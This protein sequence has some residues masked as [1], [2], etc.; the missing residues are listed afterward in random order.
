MVRTS[1]SLDRLHR[2]SINDEGYGH[3]TP[4]N[5]QRR[6]RI[7]HLSLMQPSHCPTPKYVGTGRFRYEAVVAWEQLPVGYQFVEVAGVATDSH[8]RVFV[9]N[10]GL[11]PLIVFDR[12]GKFLT[13]WGEGLFQ[14]PHG[15]CI[16]PD[17]AVYCTDDLDHTVRKFTS[18]GKLLL[19]LGTPGRAAD[20]GVAGIDYRTIQRAG[21]PFHRP[22]NLALAADG[23]MY[24]TDGYGNARVHKFAP[25]GGLLFSWGEPGRGFGQFQVPHGIAVDQEGLV[26][27]AD[28]ENSRIQLFRPNGD[29][30]SA[31]TDVARPTQVVIDRDGHVFVAE[32]GWRAGLFPWQSP[33]EPNPLGAR[34][35]VFTRAGDLLARWGDADDPT[36]PG[37]FFAPHD[38]WIDLHGDIYVGEVTMSAGGNRGAVPADCHSLQKFVLRH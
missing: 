12:D 21:P 17:D 16:G 13:S 20:T 37:N 19:T 5:H 1:R 9:F 14:R 15:I 4:R 36:E 10:R 35:S 7:R 27:V 23:S 28:R 30:L 29:F 11:H 18:V 32:L 34:L 6:L 8:D 33:P 26:Y 25:D 3:A 38:L 2:L 24:V 31:W 22:T